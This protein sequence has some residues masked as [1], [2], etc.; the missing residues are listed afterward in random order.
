VIRTRSRECAAGSPPATRSCSSI[1]QQETHLAAL[2]L[3]GD[4]AELLRGLRG[5]D[6]PVE[7][8]GLD[9][10]SWLLIA[11]PLSRVANWTLAAPLPSWSKNSVPVSPL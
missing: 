9:L 8:S 11:S 5:G 7:G 3:R 1:G 6:D 10:K 2:G 4:P